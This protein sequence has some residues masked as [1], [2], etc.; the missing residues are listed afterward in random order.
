M[1]PEETVTAG[2]LPIQKIGGAFMQQ[3][4]NAA[5]AEELGLNG[6]SLYY[7]GRGGV[8][9]D[10]DADVVTAAF[11]F[12]PAAM[13]RKAWD[14]GRTVI[15]PAQMAERY[16]EICHEWGRTR[17]AGFDK[18]GRLAEL[19]A[20]VVDAVDPAG[21]PLFAGWR[22]MPL[23]DD[24]PA[25]ANQLVHLLR[26]HRGGLHAI[27]VLAA[28]LTPLEASVSI[29]EGPGSPG[30]FGWPEPHPD[31]APLAERRAAA[32]ARTDELVLPPY[33]ELDGDECAEL[34]ELLQA[35]AAAAFAP[36]S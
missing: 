12:M 34:A 33:A 21:L 16:A 30:F 19:A 36:R 10:V 22:A 28:G 6:W 5:I 14:K 20:K 17:F 29:A 8:L 3:R 9:G 18:A 35:A 13:V 15:P 32:E 23:P 25:R 7:C 27:A 4:K 11:V 2:T 1:T 26:E 31:P 24:A